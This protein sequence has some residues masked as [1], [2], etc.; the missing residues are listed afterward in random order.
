[1]GV[2]ALVADDLRL[3]QVRDAEEVRHERRARPLVE[4]G[5]GA[6]LLDLAAV[7]DRDRVGHAHG[8]FLIVRHV[9]EGDADV[10][11]DALELDL[12]L[13]AQPQVQR[14]ERFVEQQGARPV[15]ERARQRDALLLAARELRRLALGEVAELH[16]LERLVRALERLR[17]AD[18]LALEPE[19]DVLLH[20]EVGEERVGLEHRV[21]VA[22]V[23]GM[24]GDVR[25]AEEDLALGRVLEAADHPQRR[26]LATPG[27]AEHGEEAPARDRHREVVDRRHLPE[28][29]AD[30]IQ[31]DIG[32]SLRCCHPR[33]FRL[34]DAHP[35]GC[36]GPSQWTLGRIFRHHG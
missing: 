6:G 23:R 2:H 17:L 30:A 29:L 4:V 28:A 19:R 24:L 5:R 21:D 8:L 13:F 18:L 32:L 31:M 25:A 33:S 12:E 16:E 35:S 11:L 14:A 34:T 27:R 22:L 10:L 26:R 15:H 1:M 3:D 7:H 9:H 20:A 36:T